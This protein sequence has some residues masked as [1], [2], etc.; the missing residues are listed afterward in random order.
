MELFGSQ[1]LL[2]ESGRKNLPP[3]PIEASIVDALST[4]R[5]VYA[6]SDI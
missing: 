1:Y 4:M 3:V 6:L 2:I 5:R